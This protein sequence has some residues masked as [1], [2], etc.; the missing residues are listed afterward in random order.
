LKRMFGKNVLNYAVVVFTHCD[1]FLEM[2]RTKSRHEKLWEYLTRQNS[3][4]N[5]LLKKAGNRYVLF[6]DREK[7]PGI[8]RDQVI[9][10]VKIVDRL[11]VHNKGNKYTNELFEFVKLEL[12]KEEEKEKVEIEKEKQ[13]AENRKHELEQIRVELERTKLEMQKVKNEIE[14]KKLEEKGRKQELE[15][16]RDKLKADLIKDE[17]AAAARLQKREKKV[18]ENVAEEAKRTDKDCFPS[19]VEVML[20]DG[21]TVKMEH[22]HVGDTILSSISDGQL[23]FSEVYFNP[24]RDEA[25]VGKYVN[26]TTASTELMLS[27]KHHIFVVTDDVTYSIPAEQMK[28]GDQVLILKPG[29]NKLTQEMVTGLSVTSEVGVYSPITMS[30]TIIVNGMFASCYNDYVAPQKAHALLWPVR[31]LYQ[32]APSVCKWINTPKEDGMPSWVK[33]AMDNVILPLRK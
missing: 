12:R 30:G 9:E 19:C 21:Q 25:G 33:W 29:D 4:L 20:E 1:D 7:D 13:E 5:S 22:L 32:V 24:H 23:Q 8:L 14:E 11:N 18:G 16:K 31:K 15:Q 27:P 3:R 26:V 17:Q 6:N 2:Q 10:L 28:I